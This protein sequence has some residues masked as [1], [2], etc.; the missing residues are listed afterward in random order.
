MGAR[1][2][3]YKTSYY[4]NSLVIYLKASL[5]KVLQNYLLFDE[6][7]TK[8]NTNPHPNCMFYFVAAIAY[9]FSDSN[10]STQNMPLRLTS[11]SHIWRCVTS[12]LIQLQCE[13]ARSRKKMSPYTEQHQI[14][15]ANS[16]LCFHKGLGFQSH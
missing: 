2:S 1:P 7:K 8:Q 9:S 5:A 13:P 10:S 12:Y 3:Q 15:L 6:N 16:V 14:M 11:M 4:T